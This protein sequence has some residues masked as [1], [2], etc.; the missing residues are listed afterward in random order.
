MKTVL[1]LLSTDRFAFPL[2]RYLVTEGQSHGWKVC[3][4]SM[5]DASVCDRIKQQEFN[6]DVSFIHIDRFRQCEQIIRKVSLVVAMIPDALLL[7]VADSCII[8]GK[9]MISPARLT[10]QMALRK[11]QAEENDSLLLLECGFSPGLDHITAKKAIDNIHSKGGK[12]DSFKTHS[13]SLAAGS[14][15][16]NP[17]QFK[18]TEPAAELINLGKH[19][20]RHLINGRLQHIPYHCLFN[21]AQ[22]LA[23]PGVED[24]MVSLPAGD[25]MYYQKIYQLTEASTVYKGKLFRKGFEDTWNL[26]VKLG[27]TDS[28]SRIDMMEEKSF[29]Q[30]L[31]SLLPFSLTGS[32]DDELTRYLET[33]SD[34]IEKLK[35]LG[36]F[37]DSWISGNKEVTPAILL[38]CLLEKRLSVEP[39]DRDFVIMQHQLE[40]LYRGSR[41]K[42]TATF[43]SE[44]DTPYSATAGAVGLTVGAAA[45]AVMTGSIN[46]KGLHIPTKKEIYDPILNE[47]DEIGIA[48]YVDEK[49]VFETDEDYRGEVGN[50]EIRMTK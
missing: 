8:H 15:I 13:G 10:R 41:Y 4:A 31:R 19:N 42:F 11:S 12:I 2:V 21:R 6:S 16:D 23:I 37:D 20:N 18:L 30:F 22:P 25:S 44:G 28:V 40:Y 47:L 35:W 1:I 14:C 32:L 24:K 3:V 43:T 9:R 17:W 50:Y 7:K 29:S 38:Q 36:L 46:C 39:G 49:R 5:F 33:D 48:F 45:K 34:G 26:M 27:L